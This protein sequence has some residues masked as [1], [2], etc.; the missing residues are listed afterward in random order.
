VIPFAGGTTTIGSTD[1]RPL[2][3]L[4][5]SAATKFCVYAAGPALTLLVSTALL[6]IWAK[7]L[8]KYP[9]LTK[10]FYLY[11]MTDFGRHAGYAISALGRN[12]SD[13][14]HDFVQLHQ[15]GGLH[16]LAATIGILA[17]PILI[18]RK[19][20]TQLDSLKATDNSPPLPSHTKMPILI[21]RKALTRLDSLKATDNSPPL[22]SHTK[23]P[24]AAPAA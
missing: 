2:G 5:G 7:K 13:L 22:P 6:D 4:M 11:G 3:K 8:E 19:A 12:P 9:F 17:I 21:F 16:P 15:L 20:L 1:I 24:M 18:F 23:M 14:G 10:Y